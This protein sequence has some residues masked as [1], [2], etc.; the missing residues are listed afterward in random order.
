MKDRGVAI[1]W[2]EADRPEDQFNYVASENHSQI[3]DA[4]DS[5]SH[6]RSVVFAIDQKYWD[7]YEVGKDEGYYATETYSTVP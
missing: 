3:E 5:K 4:K 7:D 1:R 6:S 2:H